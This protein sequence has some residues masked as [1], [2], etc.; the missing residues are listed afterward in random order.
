[1]NPLRT[2]AV[3][4]GPATTHAGWNE[5]DIGNCGAIKPIARYSPSRGTARTGAGTGMYV[6]SRQHNNATRQNAKAKM[7]K[8]FD[9]KYLPPNVEM[10]C[11]NGTKVKIQIHNHQDGGSSVIFTHKFNHES[12]WAI[13]LILPVKDLPQFKQIID[14]L[15]PRAVAYRMKK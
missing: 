10:S 5:K 11:A 8:K 4:E 15:L 13:G 6:Q 12:L 7:I 9:E 3:S 1:M 14:E 2:I